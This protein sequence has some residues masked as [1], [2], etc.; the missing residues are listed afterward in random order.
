MH[1]SHYGESYHPFN[2][3]V[4]HPHF[5][6]HFMPIKQLP[7]KQI[8]GRLYDRVIGIDSTIKRIVWLHDPY[9]RI[10]VGNEMK[11]VAMTVNQPLNKLVEPS[12]LK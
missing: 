3:P 1:C 8:R 6:V 4:P 5:N 7:P 2:S 11:T 9:H 12:I 10:R